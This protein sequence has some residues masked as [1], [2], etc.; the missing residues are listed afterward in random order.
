MA[1]TAN[2]DLPAS[3]WLRLAEA[4]EPSAPSDSMD[5]YLRLADDALRQADKRAYRDAIRLLEAAR[6]AARSAGCA[7]AFD[8]GLACVRERNRRRPTFMAMLD[9][10][11]LR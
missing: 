6:R 7:D 9:K 3:Q 1:T 4:R 5:L 11:G 8:E 2:H 10:A